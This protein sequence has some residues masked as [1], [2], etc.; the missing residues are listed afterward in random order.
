MPSHHSMAPITRLSLAVSIYD[1]KDG[2]ALEAVSIVGTDPRAW[3]KPLSYPHCSKSSTQSLLL[4][5][6]RHSTL[7]GADLHKL[8]NYA[9]NW[10][11][12]P[13]PKI[14]ASKIVFCVKQVSLSSAGGKKLNRQCLNN[15]IIVPFHHDEKGARFGIGGIGRASRWGWEQIFQCRAQPRRFGVNGLFIQK[16]RFFSIRVM[17][18]SW[19]N[20]YF[21]A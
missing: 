19:N 2:Q 15:A 18:D 20:C 1:P 5:S 6:P 8:E 14:V 9:T 10:R 17:I 21:L 7:T 12:L 11:A 3:C 16:W 13:I 4:K